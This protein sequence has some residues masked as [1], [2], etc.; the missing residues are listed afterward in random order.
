MAVGLLKYG[1]CRRDRAPRR[2]LRSCHGSSEVVFLRLIILS[3]LIQE[4]SESKGLEEFFRSML[5]AVARAKGNG[6]DL[7]RS[8]GG[9]QRSLSQNSLLGKSRGVR[10]GS[11]P[12]AGGLGDVPPDTKPIECGWVGPRTLYLLRQAQ[13]GVFPSGSVSAARQGGLGALPPVS[14]GGRVGIKD[15]CLIGTMLV[16]MTPASLNVTVKG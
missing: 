9:V 14:K 13:R 3:L 6:P 12:L 1:E 10:R 11:R 4:G 16:E 8:K 7:V 2:S 5:E 15:I